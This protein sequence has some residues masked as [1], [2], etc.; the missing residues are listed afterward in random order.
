MRILQIHNS[1]KQAGGEDTVVE[2]EARLLK[3]KG[4]EVHQLIKSNDQIG[5]LKS[6]IDLL[7]STHY[8]HT[9]S[10]EIRQVI[11]DIKPEIVHVHNFFPLF[12]PA[13]FTTIQELGLPSILTLHNYRIIHPN[14]LLLHK[15]KIDERGLRGSV[16]GCVKDRVYRNSFFQTAVVA[17]MIDYH[18]RKGTWQNKV[19]GFITLSNFA[20][21]KYVEWGLPEFKI[22]VKPNFV[23]EDLSKE[24]IPADLRTDFIYIGRISEEKG[25][26]QLINYWQHHQSQTLHIIGVG[27]LYDDLRKQSK[28]DSNIIWHGKRTRPEVVAQLRKVKAL[29][30]P[31][32][33]YE[34]FPMTILEAFANGIPVLTNNIG[35]HATIVEDQKNG[36]HFDLNSS[37]TVSIAIESA[38]SERRNE[39]MSHLAY[40]SFKKKYSA[41]KNYE[42]IMS[43]YNSALRS[44]G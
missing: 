33:C 37:K 35:S 4:H 19:T 14:G 41:D 17:H 9:A 39:Q 21:E 3:A 10:R 44:N 40:D 12:S 22:C 32:L 30:F 42:E 2:E 15:G 25:I 1:Y 34:N 26:S 18:R 24:P 38:V 28:Q 23:T 20:K 7:F 11:K 5:S 13:I 27:P 16:Y 6:K 43:V 31:S 36:L 29:I 8:N